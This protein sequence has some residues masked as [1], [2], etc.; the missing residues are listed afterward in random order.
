MLDEYFAFFLS[1]SC[2]VFVFI[3]FFPVYIANLGLSARLFEQVMVR[4]LVP[5]EDH[6]K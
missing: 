4:L 1:K 3:G 5:P 6:V 2:G